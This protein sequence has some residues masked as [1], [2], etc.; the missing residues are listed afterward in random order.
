MLK[1]IFRKRSG[2]TDLLW[3]RILLRSELG[4]GNYLVTV[5]SNLN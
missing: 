1:R 4:T 3:R 2:E 5:I